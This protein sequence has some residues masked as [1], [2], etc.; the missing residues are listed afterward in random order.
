MSSSVALPYRSTPSFPTSLKVGRWLNRDPIREQ[1][2]INLYGYVSNHPVN[3]VDPLGLHD[4]EAYYY[5]ST[6]QLRLTSPSVGYAVATQMESGAA[7]FKN[8]KYDPSIPDY[9][10][11]PNHQDVKS[12]DGRSGPAGPIPEGL[13]R[14]SERCAGN[15]HDHPA[16]TLTPISGNALKYGRGGPS[17]PF[18]IHFGTGIG[19][20]VPGGWGALAEKRYLPIVDFMQKV[21]PEKGSIGYLHVY[22]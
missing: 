1:G 7:P 8:G 18:V 17:G 14:I 12:P 4:V 2:G 6:G 21:I 22:R 10:N 9:R 20:I 16:Y 3:W 15:L 11:D 5:I 13:Y 19:C